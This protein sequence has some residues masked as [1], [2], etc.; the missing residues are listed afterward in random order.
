[1]TSIDLRPGW[2]EQ[3]LRSAGVRNAARDRARRVAAEATPLG[4]QVASTYEAFVEDGDGVRVGGRTRARATTMNLGKAIEHG[5]WDKPA[6]APL[7]RGAERVGLRTG[8]AR[9]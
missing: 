8:V 5:T 9:R 1:M 7:R 4:R 3:V 2:Q 6:A